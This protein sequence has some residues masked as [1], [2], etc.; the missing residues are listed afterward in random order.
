MSQALA[1]QIVFARINCFT[2]LVLLALLLRLQAVR[3]DQF[4]E[5]S[6]ERLSDGPIMSKSSLKHVQHHS[7]GHWSTSVCEVHWR[8]VIACGPRRLHV[9]MVVLLATP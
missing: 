3:E 2:H 1:M 7:G 6:S 4:G 5:I 8:Q 9:H